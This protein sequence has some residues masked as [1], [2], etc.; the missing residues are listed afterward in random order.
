MANSN[1]NS[2]ARSETQAK[3]GI[4]RG[5][6][7]AP[8]TS[9][10]SLYDMIGGEK[11]LRDLVETF[12]DVIE[13]E[14]AGKLLLVLHRRGHGVA[15]SRIE[16]FDFL[17]GFLG[18]PRLYV[19]HH[20]HSDVRYMHEHIAIGPAERDAWLNC[21]ST[22]IDRVGLDADIKQRLMTPFTRVATMLINR[23]TS[24]NI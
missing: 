10:T 7:G 14:D 19:A 3:A 6:P 2:G 9:D 8:G 1:P 15:H 20:G 18:G 17:S 4:V 5:D 22:A 23:D 24:E 12:Y 13:H 21:M 11:V 16:Q